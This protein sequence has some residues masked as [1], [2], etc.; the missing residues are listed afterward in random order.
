MIHWK[1]FLQLG[2]LSGSS[3]TNA[4]RRYKKIETFLTQTD[5]RKRS[6][7]DWNASYLGRNYH[8]IEDTFQLGKSVLSLQDIQMLRR[9]ARS[10]FIALAFNHNKLCV[11]LIISEW[12]MVRSKERNTVKFTA[13]LQRTSDL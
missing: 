6:E 12:K 10:D 7:D 4:N 1:T 13:I 9:S 3:R 11:S 8:N 5:S 2:S